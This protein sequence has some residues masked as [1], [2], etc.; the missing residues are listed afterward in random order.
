MQSHQADYFGTY[1]TMKMMRDTKGVPA[2]ASRRARQG[3]LRSGRRG[4]G[5]P[6][7]SGLAANL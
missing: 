4:I 6:P 3:S 2:T 7:H 5:P 1:R